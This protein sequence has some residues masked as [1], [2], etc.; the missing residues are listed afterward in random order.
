MNYNIKTDKYMHCEQ[1]ANIDYSVI[2]LLDEE[3]PEFPQFI[4]DVYSLFCSRNLS[5][6]IILMVNGVDG[7]L[8]DKI[9]EMGMDLRKIK[10]LFISKKY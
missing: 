5:F 2:F 6:E 3:Y 10:V 7:F 1:F 8:T 9:C 4:Q